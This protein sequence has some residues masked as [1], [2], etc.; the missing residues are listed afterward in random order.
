MKIVKNYKIWFALSL[1][2][3]LA[4]V[5]MMIT[6]GLNYGIDFTGGTMLTLPTGKVIPAKDIT[7]ALES[8][9]LNP[10]VQHSGENDETIVIKTTKSLDTEKRNEIRNKLIESFSL[11]KDLKMDGEQFGPNVG[12]EITRK[13][14]ISMGLAALG[15]LIYITVRF[16]FYY[17][18]AAIIALVHDMAV[19][20]SIYAFFNVTVNSNFI[21]A[22]LT[23]LGYSINDTIVVFD[24]IRE[25]AK[26]MRGT[27][28]LEIAGKSVEQSISRTVMTSLT[29]F[30]VIL[31][32]Y[33]LGVPT[34]K[35]FALPLMFGV[36]VGTYSSI[37][38]AGPL[39][40]LLSKEK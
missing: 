13:A 10:V 30:S 11:P 34:V 16:Q 36:I 31:F 1:V 28:K 19:L 38:L 33:I 6:S 27:P 26:Y 12:E 29:T 14:L 39:W 32:L 17:G 21:A 24:R 23:I 8:F 40:A 9:D 15:M 20:V 37:C 5:V 4:G 25:N 35:E 3:I 7:E 18:L 22:I 2:I